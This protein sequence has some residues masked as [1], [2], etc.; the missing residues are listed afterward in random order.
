MG[1]S[2]FADVS[3]LEHNPSRRIND[4]DGGRG[5]P[6]SQPPD[7]SAT[8][9]TSKPGTRR[10]IDPRHLSPAAN[11]RANLEEKQ[12]R[13]GQREGEGIKWEGEAP[14]E[15]QAPAVRDDG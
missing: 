12:G 10:P 1:R 6:P 14:A 2:T 11:R 8:A 4:D 7:A 5:R 3:A 9:F 13:G 15:P